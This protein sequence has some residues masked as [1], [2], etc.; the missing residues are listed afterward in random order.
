MDKWGSFLTSEF[1]DNSWKA[2]KCPLF[3]SGVSVCVCLSAAQV[4]GLFQGELGGNRRT[5]LA[6]VCFAH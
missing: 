5:I 4:N 6:T 1:R 2:E 3:G